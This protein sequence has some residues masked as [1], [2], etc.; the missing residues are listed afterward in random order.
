MR[1]G[2]MQEVRVL[3]MHGGLSLLVALAWPALAMAQSTDSQSHA[4]SERTQPAA[5][6]K[7]LQVFVE[8]ADRTSI[9]PLHIVYDD[10]TDDVQRLPPKEERIPIGTDPDAVQAGYSNPQV[11]GDQRTVGWTETYH[12]C[13]QSYPIPL[14]LTLYR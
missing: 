10:A 3:R 11:A 7:V 1:K 4:S 6:A 13:C 5:E 2:L 14:V 9:G 12:I 8:D